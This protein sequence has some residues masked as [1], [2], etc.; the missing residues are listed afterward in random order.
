[1]SNDLLVNTDPGVIRLPDGATGFIAIIALDDGALSVQGNI[2]DKKFALSLLDQ[3]SAL[4][5]RQPVLRSLVIPAAHADIPI[6]AAMPQTPFGE[7]RR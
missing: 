1:M 3:A 2:G 7:R 6:D 4:V 5:R